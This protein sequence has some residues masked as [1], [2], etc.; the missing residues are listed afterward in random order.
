MSE[1]TLGLFKEKYHYVYSPSSLSRQK[2]VIKAIP[3]SEI[4]INKLPIPDK[5]KPNL[6]IPQYP[7]VIIF[8]PT[9]HLM[10]PVSLNGD[11]QIKSYRMFIPNE[12]PL[13]IISYDTHLPSDHTSESIAR[14]FHEFLRDIVQEPG[15]IMGIS[16]GG[17]IA[18]PFAAMYPEWVNKLILMVSTYTVRGAGVELAKELLRLA[19]EG[20]PFTLKRKIEDLYHLKILRKIFQLQFWREWP[21]LEESM[22]P[23]ST[24]INAY[25]HL[26]NSPQSRKKYLSKIDAPTLIIGGTEDQFASVEDY[27]E[28]RDLIPNAFLEL[29]DGQ[30]HTVPIEKIFDVSDI[31]KK[32]IRNQ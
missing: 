26:L 32:F 23:L 13:Y 22:N 16:Y 25:S 19:K 2:K 6:E 28:T 7:P 29:Y 24:F 12:F 31:I 17:S 10:W 4:I 21:D 20:K 18:I 3:K 14:D 11:S 1:N 15:I 9:K 8:P 27:E 30:T 5:F